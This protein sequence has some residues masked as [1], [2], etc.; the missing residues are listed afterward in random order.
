MSKRNRGKRLR[1]V[2][3][4]KRFECVMWKEGDGDGMSAENLDEVEAMFP[5][6]NLVYIYRTPL[7]MLK[8]QGPKLLPTIIAYF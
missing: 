6:V 5:V 8:E 1:D 7:A 2:S 4:W 3:F